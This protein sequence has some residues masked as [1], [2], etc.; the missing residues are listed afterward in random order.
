LKTE[1]PLLK[2]SSCLLGEKVRFNGNHCQNDWIT[3]T[4][5]KEA[6]LVPFCP[7]MMMGLGTPRDSVRLIHDQGGPDQSN[8]LIQGKDQINLDKNVSDVS[9][10]ILA[11][12]ENCDGIILKGKSPSCGLEK[13]K[14][15]NTTNNIPDR[16]T[17]GIFVQYI[18]TRYPFA[19]MID[20]SR[21]HN[22]KLKENFIMASFAH[23][24][25]RQTQSISQLQS[26]HAQYK[27]LLMAYNQ[28]VMSQM[29]RLIANSQ[30]FSQTKQLYGELLSQTMAKPIRPASAMNVL[31]HMYGHFKKILTQDQKKN[32]RQIIHLYAEEKA[33]LA[34][35][36][37]VLK[38]ISNGQNNK[39]GSYIGSQ[40]IF[41]PYPDSLIEWQDPIIAI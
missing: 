36:L 28:N 33:P 24:R 15:Y 2:I 9:K 6:T 31:L 11:W 38:F 21:M 18:K 19:P 7:E 1:K 17:S 8:R 12:E 41:L 16:L 35:A 23:W 4:L 10:M 40:F 37:Q 13:V 20:D 27:Y 22:S 34:S 25:W 26:F 14:S 3:E 32:I 29:G 30:D 5:S 39:N